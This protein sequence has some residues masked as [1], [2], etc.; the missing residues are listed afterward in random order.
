MW[1][2]RNTPN[3]IR[4]PPCRLG[5]HNPYVYRELLATPPDEYRRLEETGHIGE[6]YAPHLP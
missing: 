6:V 5:E 4:T 3:E 1:S 2:A